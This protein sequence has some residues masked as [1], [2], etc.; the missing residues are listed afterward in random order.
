[1]PES[2]RKIFTCCV[3]ENISGRWSSIPR[4]DKSSIYV[5]TTAQYTLYGH[6]LKNVDSAK[7]LGVT[8]ANDLSW[9]K[10][11]D[12]VTS[13]AARTLRFLRRNFYNATRET[14]QATFSALVIPA[15]ENSAAAWDPH[16]WTDID[17]LEQ[18]QGRGARYVMNNYQD[19]TPGCVTTM[20]HDLQWPTLSD[21]RK[22][23]LLTLLYKIKHGLTDF[24]TD[25]S[26]ADKRT[27]GGNRIFQ[28]PAQSMVYKF[29]FYLRTIQEWNRLPP[30]GTDMGTVEGFV[31][32]TR[33]AAAD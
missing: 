4:N 6:T 33:P 5:Q 2:Y 28:P 15:M 31:A 13:K 9:G 25:V 10:H 27:R 19:R 1:M 14:R 11:V 30:A 16:L 3:T 29:S 20:L 24:Q 7:Y 17:K 22:Q 23:H 21:R 18:I 8:L 26:T 12:Q 32:A